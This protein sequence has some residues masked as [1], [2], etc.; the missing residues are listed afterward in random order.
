MNYKY[1]D[2]RILIFAREPVLGQVKT[3]LQSTLGKK[4]TY[5]LHS[6]LVTYQVAQA[7]R[8]LL[9]PIELWVTSNPKHELFQS[10]VGQSNVFEQ[11]GDDLGQRMLN[12]AS[13]ALQRS[14]SVV[15]IGADCPSVDSA[16]LEQAL[17]QL[18]QNKDLVFGPAEDG[19]YVLFGMNQVMPDLFFNIRWGTDS[20][21]SLTM[22]RVKASGL[23]YKLLEPRW[24][25]DRPEDLERLS[26]LEPPLVY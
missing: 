25:V 5:D 20:V 13:T 26:E 22:Q 19:G 24:D 9:A 11:Q 8:N 16:Y 23:T 6:A 12:A 4:Q 21:M 2:S 7:G 18:N 3:R 1:K 10:V 14:K 15:L 17:D